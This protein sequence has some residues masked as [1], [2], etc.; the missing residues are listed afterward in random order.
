MGGRSVKEGRMKLAVLN[1]G[2]ND[3]EQHF[4]DFAGLPTKDGHPPVNYHAYAACTGG[5]FY[6][7]PNKIPGPQENVLLLLRRDLAKCLKALEFLK[8]AG[9]RVVVSWKESG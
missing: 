4:R 9:K 3:P 7:D 5:S 6:K 1:P 2:G 8:A